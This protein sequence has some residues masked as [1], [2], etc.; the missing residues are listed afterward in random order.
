ME[1]NIIMFNLS[2][3]EII[4][5]PDVVAPFRIE[6]GRF[7]RLPVEDRFCFHCNGLVKDELHVITVC[8]LFQDLR[9]TLFAKAKDVTLQFDTLSDTDKLC[10]VMFS[11]EM[12][13]LTATICNESLSRRRNLIYR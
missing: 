3:Q 8:P 12:V 9:D 6:T 13:H 5:V 4:E 1:Q 2:C 11:Q 7:E 10:F